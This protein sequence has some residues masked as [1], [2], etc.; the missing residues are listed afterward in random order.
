M[1]VLSESRYLM[2]RSRDKRQREGKQ[3]YTFALYFPKVENVFLK[4]SLDVVTQSLC[5]WA[6]TESTISPVKTLKL[7]KVR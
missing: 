7:L 1:L 3:K 2:E 6:G 5:G 4:V